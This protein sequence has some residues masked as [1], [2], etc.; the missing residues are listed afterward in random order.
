MLG[1][2]Q[3]L[4]HVCF[5]APG[6]SEAIVPRQKRSGAPQNAPEQARD[7][8][9]WRALEFTVGRHVSCSFGQDC[10]TLEPWAVVAVSVSRA[11]Q[12]FRSAKEVNGH[13]PLA[14][15]AV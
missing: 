11:S 15:G 4:Y 7:P 5:R 13:R 14:S 6:T 12:P 3:V 1:R 9:V 2:E 8:R 10:R